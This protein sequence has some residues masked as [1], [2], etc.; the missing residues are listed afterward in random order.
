MYQ[1][2][3]E[4][5]SFLYTLLIMFLFMIPNYFAIKATLEQEENVNKLEL[6]QWVSEVERYIYTE[7]VNS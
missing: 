2:S 5:S 4:R 7:D 3:E 6:M 1:T